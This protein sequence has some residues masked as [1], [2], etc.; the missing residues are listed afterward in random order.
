MTRS[1]MIVAGEA[2]G[3]LHG[4]LLLRALRSWDPALHAFGIG[5]QHLIA[6]GLEVLVPT[7]EVATMGLTE[8]LG[9]L[10]RVIRAYRQARRALRTRRPQLLVLIDYPEF[11]L[12]LA[13]YAKRLG[14]KVFYYISPQV[15]AWRRGRV[16][17]MRRVIDRLAVV[18]PF[19]EELYNDGGARVA[20]FVGHPL[21]DLVAP[22]RAASETRKLYGLKTDRPLLA[23]LPGSRRK[24]VHALAPSALATARALAERGWQSAL[25]L[26]PTLERADIE[27][28]LAGR[29][30]EGI[31]V[32]RGDT[33]NLVHAAD[34]ALVASGTA[35]LETALL[36]KPM[37]IVYRV[38]PLTYALGRMLVRVD[39]IGMPNLIL[40][41]R[42]AP[43][44]LQ[45][46]VHPRRLVPAL[47]E[48][49]HARERFAAAWKELRE[50]L[51]TPGAAQRAAKLAWELI[52]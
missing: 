50:R 14:L 24:E 38:S 23:L 27:A 49:W 19:E 25:A 11:N 8:T 48:V 21:I 1:V 12:R 9:S 51:G 4:A 29:G 26:A 6:E 35:T 18:F 10:G 16:R 28:A 17:F 13:R 43:E 34:V 22:T 5:G 32:V 33:Y 36:G 39:H 46:E 37:V 52:A 15:W 44:F 41:R 45:G 47:E 3:D 7:H 42:V 30:L 31:P 2:S 40:G 20:F